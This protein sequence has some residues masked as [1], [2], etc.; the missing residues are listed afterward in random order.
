MSFTQS[1]P[2]AFAIG[3]AFGCTLERAG[4]GDAKKLAGQFY[5][6]DF[7]VLKV[8]FSAIVTAMLGAF[9]LGRLGLIDLAAIYVPETFLAPQIA[10]GLIFGVGFVLAGLCPG[11]SCVAA[12]SGRGDGLATVGGLL[13]GVL[14][15]GLAMPLIG[16]FYA[17]TARGPFTLPQLT[18]APYGV[19]V[20][21][22]VLIALAV[23]AGVERL[24]RRA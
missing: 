19:V 5:L 10:G 17:S 15:T 11:T 20:A 12:A 18:G 23:F 8:M 22:I 3:A 16:G 7:T 14:L 9:W 21:A 1:L 6:Q 24:E 2:V 13:V 4:L